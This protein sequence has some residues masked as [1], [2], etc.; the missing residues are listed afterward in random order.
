MAD[1][2]FTALLTHTVDVYRRNASGTADEWGAIPE[3]VTADSTSVPCLVQQ[4][5]ETIEFTRRGKKIQTRLVVFFEI[6][7]DVLEDD[8]LEFEDKKYL[9]I[10]VE[11]A[12][13]IG[14]HKEVYIWNMEN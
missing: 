2:A 7:A 10:S 14:H 5:E 3:T 1:A 8:I 12:G 4:Q 13:G 6:T 9:V 11:D